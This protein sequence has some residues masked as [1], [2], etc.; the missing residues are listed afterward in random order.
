MEIPHM[1]RFLSYKL[2]H[3][4]FRWTVD[5]E[6]AIT[7]TVLNRLNFTKYK[8]HTIVRWGRNWKRAPKYVK[9]CF[10]PDD[11]V[12]QSWDKREITKAIAV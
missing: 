1:F 4:L 12:R 10:T 11:L 9:I 3:W 8:E 6:N 5:G 2:R 7:L